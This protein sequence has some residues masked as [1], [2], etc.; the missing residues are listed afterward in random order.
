MRRIRG[1]TL[2]N[3][4]YYLNLRFPTVLVRAGLKKKTHQ[5]KSLRTSDFRKAKEMAAREEALH[6]IEVNQLLAQIGDSEASDDSPPSRHLRELSKHERRDLVRKWFIQ[7]E[8]SAEKMRDEFQSLEDGLEKRDRLENSQVDLHRYELRGEEQEIDWGRW[9]RKR[10]EKEGIEAEES[11]LDWETVQFFRKAVIEVTWRTVQA[12]RG[13]THVA[14]DLD[15]KE[16]GAYGEE[17]TTSSKINKTVGNLCDEFLD[18]KAKAGRAGKTMNKYRQ[19]AQI[20]REYFGEGCSLSK[21]EFEGFE[22]GR[23]LVEFLRR[24][25][26][27]ADQRY[28]GIPLV[29]AATLEQN[30][31]NPCFISPKSQENTFTDV[32]A[33]F[34]LG[35]NLRWITQNPLDGCHVYLPKINERP[36]LLLSG[37]ELTSILSSDEFLRQRRVEKRTDKEGRFWVVLLCL[38]HGMRLNEAAS[39]LISDVKNEEGI[40][41]L[42]LTEFDEDGN[43]V[44]QLKTTSS[45]RRIPIH[46]E[47]LAIGFLEQ[48]EKV[49]QAGTGNRL[50]PDLQP[51][52]TGNCGSSVSKWFGRLRNEVIG[53]PKVDGDKSIHSLR[54][55]VADA[56]RTVTDSDEILYAIGEWAE[57]G[58]G[59]SSRRYGRGSLSKLKEII[60]QIQF[61]GFDPALLRP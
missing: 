38:F 6:L 25:P 20:T 40:W 12:F 54:H 27:R 4:T 46:K 24:I 42:D 48:I 22:L 39:L 9:L 59:N 18:V 52:A 60:D 51:D 44:K 49:K 57:N 30:S 55:A 50:F 41:F 2:I 35:R 19:V 1:T 23:G 8:L 29:K 58:K 15:F 37:E 16:F 31:K 11:D 36:R 47:L 17:R 21:L 43:H 56:I 10:L 26:K 28:K 5:K 34:S 33:I 14:R 53:K 7:M 61:R 13:K 45:P 3:G 32:K